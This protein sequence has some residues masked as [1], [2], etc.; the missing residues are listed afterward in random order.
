M[1]PKTQHGRFVIV[2]CTIVGVFL[3]SILVASLTNSLNMSNLEGT[4]LTV[5]L[6]L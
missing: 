4:S 6:K 5:L 3:F 2:L 1:F